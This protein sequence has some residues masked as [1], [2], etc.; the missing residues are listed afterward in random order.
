MDLHAIIHLQV[1]GAVTNKPLKLN[2]NSHCSNTLM[3]WHSCLE[4]YI[5]GLVGTP[6]VRGHK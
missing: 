3:N 6:V 2:Y 1:N 5:K 4:S